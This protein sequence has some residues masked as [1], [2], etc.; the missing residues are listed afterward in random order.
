MKQGKSLMELAQAVESIAAAKVDLVA[1]TRKMSLSDTGQLVVGDREFQPTQ[2]CHTQLASRLNIP[3]AYYKSMQDSAPALLQSN[4]N[5]WL[6]ATSER[7]MVRG[8]GDTARAFLSDRYHRI[9]NEHVMET[10]LPVLMEIGGMKIVSCEVTE[11]KLYIKATSS[12]IVAEVRESKRVGD[13]VEAGLMITNS[14]VGLGSLSIK[15]FMNFLV[16]TNGMVRDKMAFTKYHVGRKAEDSADH[17]LSDA[18]KSLEDRAVLSRVRDVI[19]NCMSLDL[20]KADIQLMED[21]QRQKITGD[22][23]RA[24][25]LVGETLQL[26]AVERSGVLRNLIE[27]GDLSRYS[28]M[29]AVTRFAQDTASYDRAT[30]IEALGG[31]VLDLGKQEWNRIA[32]AA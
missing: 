1:D 5:H 28:L 30:E 18:T 31:R 3:A 16:C 17:L 12:V 13:F 22:V 19:K 24:I 26:S 15:P 6:H 9:D 32:E 8:L 2:N 20:L 25:E 23:P 10:I 14:E 29:N 4:V 21:A 11:N 27:S 7:R